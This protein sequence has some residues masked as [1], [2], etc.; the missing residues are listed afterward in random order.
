MNSYIPGLPL[1]QSNFQKKEKKDL[2]EKRNNKIAN[3]KTIC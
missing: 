1:I 3:M 2:P